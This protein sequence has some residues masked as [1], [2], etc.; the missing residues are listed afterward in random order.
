[1]NGAVCWPRYTRWTRHRRYSRPILA[2]ARLLVLFCLRH[3]VY[4]TRSAMGRGKR[5]GGKSCC[6]ST[7]RDVL[8]GSWLP[9]T[10]RSQSARYGSR[11]RSL[12]A[13][14]DCQSGSRCQHR[15][16]H[17]IGQ[18][19]RQCRVQRVHGRPRC[20]V[21]VAQ[22]KRFSCYILVGLVASRAM[23]LPNPSWLAAAMY[24]APT[25]CVAC[26]F[27]HTYRH[28]LNHGCNKRF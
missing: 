10:G 17:R 14:A 4:W 16:S 25:C 9:V 1:V 28:F 3:G 7:G 15:L 18:H 19:S 6:R 24:V 22:V 12:H 27:C 23:A 11:D 20:V 5:R 26:Q 8:A 13:A 21:R 2:T